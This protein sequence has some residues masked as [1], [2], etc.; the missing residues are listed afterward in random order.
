MARIL[1]R[2]RTYVTAV[3]ILGSGA[4]IGLGAPEMAPKVVPS[5][6]SFGGWLLFAGALVHFG[7]DRR[8]R[9]AEDA[10]QNQAR[11][12]LR[13][14]ESSLNAIMDALPD[15]LVVIDANCLVRSFNPAARRLFGEAILESIDG[16]VEDLLADPFAGQLRDLLGRHLET[17]EPLPI[18]ERRE[19]VALRRD[20]QTRPV[21][22]SLAETE[23]DGTRRFILVLHDITTR[24]GTLAR[25]EVADKV[26]ESTMEG[27]MVTD[28]RGTMLWVNQG[29]CRISGYDREEVIGQNASM[30]KSGLQGA[31]F[32]G[33]MWSQIRETGEWAGEIWNRR[34]DGD[35]YPEW[36]TIKALPDA[37]G[38]VTRYVGVFSDISKHKRAEETIRTLTYYDAVTRLPNRYLFM[39]RLNQ[40]IERSQRSDRKIAVVMIG[41]D[42]FRQIN[43]SLGPQTGDALLRAVA[44]R[45]ATCLRGHDTV[46]RLR[47]NTFCCLLTELAQSHDSHMVISR[48][49]DCFTASY[50]IGEHELF[51]TAAVGVSV[52]PMDGNDP[53]ELVQK[54]ETAMNRSK[55]RADNIY[56]FYTPEM[57]TN[58]AERL[59][60]ETELRKALARNEFVVYYQPKVETSSGRIVGAEALLRW[61]HHEI[62]M[63]SPGDFIPLAEETGLIVPI[64]HWVL[65]H[66]CGQIKE[67]QDEGLLPVQVA[68]N[69]SAHQFRQPDLIDRVVAAMT[70][71]GIDP[72]LVELEL[73]ESAVMRNAEVAIQTLMDLHA[74]GVRLAVDDFGTGYSSLSYLKKFPLDKLKIDRSFVMDIESNPASVEIVGAIIAMAHSL[75]LAV[76]G[77]GVETAAQLAILKT[78]KCDEI[79][80]FYY[81]KP[82]PAATFAAMLKKGRLKGQAAA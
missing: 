31:K 12:A 3:A 24:K 60:L 51:V 25:L 26:L 56:Q 36:L 7:L 62:G 17:G 43:E 45:L 35:A 80:G 73:T 29:F 75:N 27:V 32:Y 59:R 77:E 20:G 81:A 4:L 6:L 23:R 71:H 54:A 13:E 64:G 57:H 79:Q 74:Q 16:P 66:V 39:D 2:P 14:A 1:G 33:E 65:E 69:I 44:E 53:D 48:L 40:A 63:I 37:S 58:S 68:V 42:R 22:M 47:G 18:A 19:A 21:E 76:I 30:L 70:N 55:E 5:P 41:L 28:R 10:C 72:A 78:L 34:K 38:Q 46:A 8:A 11:T 15:A 82:V 52:Y 67:W 61:A 49:M 9:R 50:Q